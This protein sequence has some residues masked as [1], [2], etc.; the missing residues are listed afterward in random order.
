MSVIQWLFRDVGTLLVLLLSL[1][2][3]DVRIEAGAVHLV[4]YLDAV[5]EEEWE[6][7]RRGE[8][9]D[10]VV[11]LFRNIEF[12]VLMLDSIRQGRAVYQMTGRTALSGLTCPP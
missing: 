6:A 1:N 12:A 3:A 8:I 5:I 4:E 10:D 9:S 2:F 11:E 7:L